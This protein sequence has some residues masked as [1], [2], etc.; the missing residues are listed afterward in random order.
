MSEEQVLSG[1]DTARE[2][3]PL[4]VVVGVVAMLAGA[5]LWALVTVLTRMELGLMA[6]VVGFV[7]GLGIQKV[8]KRPNKNFGILGAVL[9]LVGCLLGNALSFVA[10]AAQQSG[11][12][13]TAVLMT[14]SSASLLSAMA[15]NFAAMD[16]LFYGIAIYEG[17]KFGSR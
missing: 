17:F 3:V 15:Q 16:L 4:I 12:S 2:N 7:V 13:F 10:F 14:V 5:A 8:R 6:I 1:G 11:G 9:A